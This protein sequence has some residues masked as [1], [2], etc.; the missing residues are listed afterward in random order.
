MNNSASSTKYSGVLAL[1][2]PSL[3]DISPQ[4]IALLNRYFSTKTIFEVNLGCTEEAKQV[5]QAS[6][7]NPSIRAAVSS[8]R[9]LREDLEQS[10]DVSASVTQ[11]TPS[12]DYGLQQYCM[13]LKGLASN[14]SNP[15]TNDLKSALL[16]CQVFISIEQARWNVAAMTQHIIQGLMIMRESR[17]R[18][19]I[20]ASDTFVPARHTE[21]PLLDVFII[22]LFAA[23]CKFAEPSATTASENAVSPH[24]QSAETGETRTIAPDMRTELTKISTSTLGFLD[25]LS[26]P[27]PSSNALRLVLEK[28]LLLESLK[29]WLKDLE[30]V[31]SKND[32]LNSELV[33]VSFLRL[34]HQTL[35]VIIL[36]TIDSSPESDLE[37]WTENDRLRGVAA[38]VD[39]RLE[40]YKP[41]S[42]TGSVQ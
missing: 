29:M 27:T 33:S 1:I 30:L 11:K 25:N 10:R 24:Q 34:F 40:A 8:L 7:T 13:A 9:A 23:P 19:H 12:H 3:N 21:L 31:Q 38:Y 41:R 20:D 37:L 32:Y 39:G 14:L 36:G 18:P 35:Q 26:H 28:V 22:K 42:G 17:V 16:C 4:D 5:L 6:L 15:G 2:R